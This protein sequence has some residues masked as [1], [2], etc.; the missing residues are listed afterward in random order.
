[1]ADLSEDEDPPHSEQ[2]MSYMGFCNTMDE[3]EQAL[4]V[5]QQLAAIASSSNEPT[6]SSS[7]V[8]ANRVADALLQSLEDRNET[9]HENMEEESADSDECMERVPSVRGTR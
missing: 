5:G 9:V 6:G 2:N 3:V 8:H 7:S 1:M 4:A